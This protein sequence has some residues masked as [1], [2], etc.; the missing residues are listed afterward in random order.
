MPEIASDAALLI[1]PQSIESIAQA[2]E[3]IL[4][5]EKIRD[6]LIQSGSQ[7]L[8][9]YSWDRSADLVWSSIQEELKID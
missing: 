8:I 6:K 7:R 4:S 5:S 1:D 9:N 3:S 2:M